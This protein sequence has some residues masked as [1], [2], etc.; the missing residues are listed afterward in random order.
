MAQTDVRAILQGM[1]A[2]TQPGGTAAKYFADCAVS[3]AGKTGT[4]QSEGRDAYAWFVA[5][6]PAE[7]PSIAIAVVIGQGGHG[8]YAAPVA[9]AIIE[10]YFQPG[11]GASL[12]LDGQQLP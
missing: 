9:K 11:V 12:P 6:A 4:A 3:V 2:V 1:Q 10:A 7:N 5:A 8:G